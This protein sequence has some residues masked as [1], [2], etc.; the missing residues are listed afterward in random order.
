MHVV[1]NSQSLPEGH[2]DEWLE[3]TVLQVFLAAAK[4]EFKGFPAGCCEYMSSRVESLLGFPRRSGMFVDSSG[5]G[6]PHAWNL[7]PH[8]AQNIDLTASQFDPSLREIYITSSEGSEAAD[9][10]LDGVSIGF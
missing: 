10:Y 3:L 7:N 4:Q 8:T 2:L 6:H 1:S 9:T 5:H